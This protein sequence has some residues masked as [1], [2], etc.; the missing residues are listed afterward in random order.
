VIV[1]VL[2]FLACGGPEP[3]DIARNLGS[4]NPVVREDTAR[5]ARNFESP[6]VIKALIGALSDPS[7]KVRLNAIDSLVLLEADE[8][9]PTLMNLVNTDASDLVKKE[10]VDALGRLGDKQAVPVLL[11]HIQGRMGPE[12][13][14][15]LNAIWA[16]GSLGDASALP[17]LSKLREHSDPYVAW[18]AN[19]ALRAL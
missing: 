6:E 4:K 14:P 12:G 18:N 13:R 7:E 3:E 16:L 15:P 10:A 17:L 9:V 19:Q 1:G 2:F 5:I 8:A 11:A